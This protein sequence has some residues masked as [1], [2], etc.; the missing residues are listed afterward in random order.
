MKYNKTYY[1]Y[2]LSLEKGEIAL[3]VQGAPYKDSRLFVFKHQDGYYVLSDVKSGMR[4]V[5]SKKLKDL[6]QK[7]MAVQ[8][9][10]EKIISKPEY[11]RNVEK[12]ASLLLKAQ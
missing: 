9:S 7:F 12:F 4:V 1:I 8:E 3:P 2:H 11:H 6:D 5:K 10:Y